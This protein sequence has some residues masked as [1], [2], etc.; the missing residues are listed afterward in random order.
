MVEVA[1]NSTLLVAANS[2]VFHH[3]IH[4]FFPGCWTLGVE[5][6]WAPIASGRCCK[7]TAETEIQREKQV[8][9]QVSISILSTIIKQWSMYLLFEKLEFFRWTTREG[10]VLGCRRSAS[11]GDVGSKTWSGR[12]RRLRHWMRGW[13]HWMGISGDLLTMRDGV[14][15]VKYGMCEYGLTWFNMVTNGD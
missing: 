3:A 1:L 8:L 13:Q 14:K 6:A 15:S 2:S 11:N 7:E 5:Q 10:R 4:G 12:R 9:F